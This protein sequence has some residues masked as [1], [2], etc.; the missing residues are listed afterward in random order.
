[1]A[2][3]CLPSLFVHRCNRI[4]RSTRGTRI[5][6]KD[7]R[8]CSVAQR[9]V[10]AAH[11]SLAASPASPFIFAAF[12]IQLAREPCETGRLAVESRVNVCSGAH[13]IS[14]ERDGSK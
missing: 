14:A 8:K 6:V 10:G 12:R 2:L 7:A 11:L 5:P 9:D 13:G 3:E 1:M 4:R